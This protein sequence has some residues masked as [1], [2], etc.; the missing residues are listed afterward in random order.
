MSRGDYVLSDSASELERLRL[1]ARVWEPETEA[2][3]DRLGTT[4]GWHCLD[5]G[6]GAM[7]ILG[8][9]ARRVGPSGRVVGVD[10]DPVQLRGA[11][12]FVAENALTNVEILESDAYAS[13]LPAGSFDLT[14]VRFLFAPVGRDAELMNE[15]WRL[16]KPGGIIA[17]QEPD[18]AAWRCYPLSEAWDRLKAAIVEAFR[19]GGG[20]FD[21]GRRTYMM[22]RDR[23]AENVQMRAAV[24]AL[25]PGDPYLRLPIQFATSLRSRILDG[26][27]MS[28]SELDAAIGECEKVAADPRTTG[29]TF[30]VTQVW[31][32]KPL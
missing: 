32:R 10:I 1:Q 2:W 21:A 20:D 29:V 11:R 12:A 16:T 27:L 28:R 31:A 15:L 9:L 24:V 25:A 18:A 13:P 14:H 5:L 17:I 26:G 3:L 6:C 7:G 30:V 8:P 22:L 23:G 4:E 19:R